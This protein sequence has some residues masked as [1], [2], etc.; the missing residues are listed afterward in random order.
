[1]NEVA[2]KEGSIVYNFDAIDAEIDRFF[3]DYDN[4]AFTEESKKDAKDVVALARKKQKEILQDVKDITAKWNEPV[5][6]LKEQAN[7]RVGRYDPFICKVTDFLNTCEEKRKAE[8][9]V[10]IQEIYDELVPEGEI[11]EYIPLTRIQ[12][13]K[14]LNATFTDKQIK[15]DIFEQKQKVK[16]GL[17]MILRWQSDVEDKAIKVFKDTL[18]ISVALDVISSYE[19]NKKVFKAKV[20]EET[21]AEVV[22]SFV[23]VASGEV[24]CYAYNIFL[25]EDGK[26]KLEAFMDSVGIEYNSKVE[27]GG[28]KV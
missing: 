24:K 15:D 17:E 8:K 5:L 22:D 6:R 21:R 18:D 16:S 4:L 3:A 23:P 1:M 13:E 28:F 19:Q 14:W 20:E 10:H 9:Q 2:I 25:N 7:E 11:Q 27:E 12:S 26:A